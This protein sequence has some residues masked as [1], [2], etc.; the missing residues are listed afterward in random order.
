MSGTEGFNGLEWEP[1]WRN[2]KAEFF[3]SGQAAIA[4]KNKALTKLGKGPQPAPGAIPK[5]PG[6]LKEN[7]YGMGP[8]G[9]TGP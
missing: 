3:S 4:L 6:P 7:I 8:G 9:R 1:S 2:N 5:P